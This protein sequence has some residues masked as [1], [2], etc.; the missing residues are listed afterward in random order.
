MTAATDVWSMGCVFYYIL[1]GRASPFRTG[2]EVEKV[3][4]SVLG[5]GPCVQP[6]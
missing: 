5:S 4:P 2:Q 6:R 3:R 1:T